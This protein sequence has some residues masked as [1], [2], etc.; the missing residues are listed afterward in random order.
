MKRLFVLL[1]VPVFG[2]VFAQPAA[3]KPATATAGSTVVAPSVATP[4]APANAQNERLEILTQERNETAANLAAAVKAQPQAADKP[5]N[6]KKISR[7]QGDLK[8]LDSEIARVS[9][10]TPVVVK[11]GPAPAAPPKAVA[12]PS[13]QPPPSPAS[14]TADQ[15]SESEPVAF[16]PWDVFKNFGQKGNKP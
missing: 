11:W 12:V 7:L 16:E 5:E 2:H 8:A 4:K 10:E 15:S 3:S 6:L 14:T 13:Q 1:L 9:K